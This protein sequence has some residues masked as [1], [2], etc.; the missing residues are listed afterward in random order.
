M[1]TELRVALTGKRRRLLAAAL[2]SVVLTLALVLGKLGCEPLDSSPDGAVR[3]LIAAAR[4]G[5]T[6][7]VFELLGPRTRDWLAAAAERATNTVGGSRRY[8][9]ADMLELKASSESGG[10]FSTAVRERNQDN[11]IVEIITGK[12]PAGE[13]RVAAVKTHGRWRV[14]LL[15][16]NGTFERVPSI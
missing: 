14:E 13:T 3:A 10:V 16:E 4:A 6:T 2:G 11:A 5:D 8:R 12:E 15:L 7:T 1:L 9:A